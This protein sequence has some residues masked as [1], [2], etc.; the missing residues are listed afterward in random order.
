MESL[1]KYKYYEAGNAELVFQ[2]KWL[3][4]RRTCSWKGSSFWKVATS[5]NYMFCMFKI[6]MCY[7]KVAAPGN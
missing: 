5:K 1:F 2:K 6:S 3:F 4:S 7:Q